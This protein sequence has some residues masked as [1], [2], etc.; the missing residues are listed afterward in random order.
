MVAVGAYL[1]KQRKES[2]LTQEEVGRQLGVTGRAVSDWE[3]GR[4]SPGFDLMVRL[5]R[6]IG[7]S[8]EEAARLLL[9]DDGPVRLSPNQQSRIQALIDDVG[10]DA[11]LDA[12][13]RLRGE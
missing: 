9:D 10:A 12:V 7:G 4:Y 6:V 8:V 13:Q 1:Q 5:L 11:V 2:G 3:A